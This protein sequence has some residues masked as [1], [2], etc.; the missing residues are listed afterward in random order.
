[1]AVPG[2]RVP[3]GA[4]RELADTELFSVDAYLRDFEARVD[5]RRAFDELAFA[6]EHFEVRA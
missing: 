6:A 4:P 3:Q 2:R 1:M 5:L